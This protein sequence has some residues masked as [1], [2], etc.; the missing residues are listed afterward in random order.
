MNTNAHPC[1]GSCFADR[2]AALQAV[3]AALPSI[4]RVLAE[5]GASGLGV[6]CIVVM[7]PG[8]TPA[9]ATF[10]EAVLLEFAVGDRHR[11]DIDYAALARAKARLSWTGGADSAVL[12]ATAAHRLRGGDSLLAGAVW[13]DGIV[14]AAS[15]AEPWCDEACALCVAAHLRSIAKRHHAEVLRDRATVAPPAAAASQ[16]PSPEVS[17]SRSASSPGAR[18]S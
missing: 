18:R 17:S 10:D 12:Q 8:L 16:G 9:D 2:V 11:W 1:S 15:G 7:D 14:V 3:D 13:L 5:P 4:E 6:L